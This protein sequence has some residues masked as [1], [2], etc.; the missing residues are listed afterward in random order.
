MPPTVSVSWQDCPSVPW[1]GLCWLSASFPATRLCL[2]QHSSPTQL[3][4]TPQTRLELFLH[5][6]YSSSL[7]INCPLSRS[8]SYPSFSI[9]SLDMLHPQRLEIM[10]SWSSNGGG[11]DCPCWLML[12]DLYL[13]MSVLSHSPSYM[14]SSLKARVCLSELSPKQPWTGF[15]HTEDSR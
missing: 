8:K 12:Y 14:V 10:F 13:Y 7:D 2:H 15:L 9:T 6:C 11:G 3:L 1:P 5:S 4:P